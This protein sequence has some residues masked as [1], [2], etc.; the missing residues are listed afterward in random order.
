M[1]VALACFD[2]IGISYEFNALATL[3]VSCWYSLSVSVWVIVS[4]SYALQKA[5]MIREN[6]KTDTY[7][8]VESNYPGV[9]EFRKGLCWKRW[10][11]L[12]E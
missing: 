7:V 4:K 12:T 10:E 8:S 6:V 1:I 11:L 2:F 3:I 5:I 9:I